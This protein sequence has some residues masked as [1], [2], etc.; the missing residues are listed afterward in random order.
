MGTVKRKYIESNGVRFSYLETGPVEAPLLILFHGGAL[1]GHLNWSKHYEPL[2][3][4][5]FHIISP[6]HRG[7]G[8]TNNPDSKFTSYGQLAWDMIGFLEALGLDKQKPSV[9]GHSSGAL[10]ALH[11]S[12]YSP[13]LFA[14]Q[15]LIGIHPFI[16]VSDSFKRGI[17]RYYGTPNYRHPPTKGAYS[18]KFPLHAMSLWWAHKQTNWYQ[19]MCQAWPM[20]IRPLELDKSDYKKIACPTLVISGTRDEFGTRQE[21]AELA[22]RIDGAQVIALEGENH[23]FPVYKPELLRENILPF[24]K[25]I[26]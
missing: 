5:H 8:R 9:V 10:I 11:M 2:A 21:S 19:L 12:V 4:Q 16:G 22:N 18:I 1:T 6:D 17:E 26:H 13:K 20:W 3:T 23:M 15:I 24:L 7:H 14:R 25:N